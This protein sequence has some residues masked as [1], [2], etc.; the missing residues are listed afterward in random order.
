MYLHLKK[1]EELRYKVK[2]NT[3]WEKDLIWK[4]LQPRKR[5]IRKQNKLRE[6]KMGTALVKN[7]INGEWDSVALRNSGRTSGARRQGEK[8]AQVPYFHPG[9]T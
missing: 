9:G 5:S 3:G 8:I 7:F 2:K 1:I 6:I 4:E